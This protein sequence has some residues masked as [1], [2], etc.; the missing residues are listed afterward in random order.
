MKRF[1]GT[2]LVCLVVSWAFL[3]FGGAMIFENFWALLVF[4]ALVLTVLI[5]AFEGQGEQIEKL[6]ARI[7]ALEQAAESSATGGEADAE[8]EETT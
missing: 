7:R 4:C 5:L 6:E 2:F 1:L 3:F 8:K